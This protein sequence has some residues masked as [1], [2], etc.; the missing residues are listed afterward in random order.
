MTNLFK[1]VNQ[2]YYIS[3]VNDYNEWPKLESPTFENYLEYHNHHQQFIKNKIGYFSFE[4]Q[5][6]NNLKNASEE[7]YLKNYANPCAE[8]RHDRKSVYVDKSEDKISI[9]VFQYSRYR[10]VGSK[11]FRIRTSCNYV[12]FNHKTN[13]LYSGWIE[14]YHKKKKFRRSVKRNF[15]SENPLNKIKGMMTNILTQSWVN[16]SDNLI[17]ISDTVNHVIDL[18]LSSIPN[19]ENYNELSGDLKLYKRYLDY[20]GIKYPNNWDALMTYYPQPTKKVLRKHKFKYIDTLMSMA[21]VNG[22]KIKR[23]LHKV[24]SCDFTT[25]KFCF[26]FFGKNYILAQ[27]DEIIKQMIENS[28]TYS[29][30]QDITEVELSNKERDNAFKVFRHVLNGDIDVYTYMD[31][32]RFY[33]VLN[34][35]ENLKWKSY[36]YDTFVNEHYLWSEKQGYY[37]QG[38]VLRVY[39]ERFKQ[40]VEAPI[41]GL[42]F[43]YLPKLLV[44]SKE[45]N[46]ESLIQS[47]CVKT[48]IKKESSI[49]FS[50]RK[51]DIDSPDR[52]TVEYR[53]FCTAES[54]LLHQNSVDKLVRVQSLGRFNNRL[55][56]SWESCLKTLDE[57]VNKLVNDGIFELP[58]IEYTIGGEKHYSELNI[59]YQTNNGCVMSWENPLIH[60]TKIPTIQ[61]TRIDDIGLL[62]DYLELNF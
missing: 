33:R 52:A 58:K 53:I 2:K 1:I 17:N 44:D 54:M 29:P 28:V 43:V 31:H 61:Q 48:Y 42:D 59:E 21:D 6:G 8:V 18:F 38:D 19:I 40:E 16:N 50:I 4:T 12:T 39:G 34:R 15:F 25:L 37:S 55:D 22:D 30:N 13:S 45:Y 57:R 9:K 14:D 24:K 26:N 27:D 23:V 32:I 7:D 56:E 10:N 46:K 5:I 41:L 11:F 49:I 51:G 35:V 60:L 62:N 3:L 47:N 36:N 20:S